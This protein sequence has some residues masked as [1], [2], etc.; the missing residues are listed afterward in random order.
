MRDEPRT[1]YRNPAHAATK[2]AKREP[3]QVRTIDPK[4]LA[5]AGALQS[6]PVRRRALSKR[7]VIALSLLVVLMVAALV[8]ISGKV[9]GQEPTCYVSSPVLPAQDVINCLQ[10]RVYVPIMAR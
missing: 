10:A 5:N 3:P 1:I 9:H 2:P 8:T 7:A 6:I 4:R